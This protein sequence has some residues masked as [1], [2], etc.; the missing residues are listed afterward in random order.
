MSQLKVNAISDA[1]GANGNAI[2]LATDG[3]CTAKITNNL[4]N[5]NLVNNGSMKIA[6]RGDV[7][8]VEYGYG[9]CDRWR[10]SGGSAA[11]ITMKQGGTGVSP[12]DKGFGFCQHFDVT[13]ADA[14]LAAGDYNML[15]Y[16]WEGQD[17]QQIKKGTSEAESLTV[18]FWVSSPKTGTHILE[19]Y[20]Q[21]N[22]RQI[23][24]AYTVSSANTWE[25]KTVTF[26]GDTS[27]TIANSNANG[28][29]L[30]FWLCAGSTYS[31]GSLNTSW[32]AITNANR[33]VGQVN[34]MDNTSNDFKLTGV[35]VELG[36]VATDFEH[37]SYGD[38][39][40]RCQRYY[41]VIADVIYDP[42]CSG[43]AFAGDMVHG[44][45]HFHK[46]MRDEPSMVKAGGTNWLIFRYSGNNSDTNNSIDG[47]DFNL[48][49]VSKTLANIR[50]T[51]FDFG[52]NN[53]MGA[54]GV[55][56]TQSGSALLAF[57]SEL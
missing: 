54:G 21:T 49:Q 36:D 26:A 33:A 32:A 2:T 29:T 48:Q 7:T 12:T 38:E 19:L 43:A 35:Q 44:T 40:A 23:S 17:L 37:R 46:P 56:Y 27:G 13:T 5:R 50:F 4:S 39:L 3:T 16:K 45:V 34:C 22:S 51:G 28:L 30:E 6:Q 52:N 41:Q 9:G 47:D 24:K 11:R 18:S 1:A 57:N 14:S 8:G 10:F 15:S 53:M 55:L 31:S 20:D 42:L 25:K